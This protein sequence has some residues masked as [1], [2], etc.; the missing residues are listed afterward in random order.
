MGFLSPCSR[1]GVLKAST[2]DTPD[3]PRD[4]CLLPAV[5]GTRKEGLGLRELPRRA[6]PRP[7]HPARPLTL[8]LLVDHQ[9]EVVQLQDVRQPAQ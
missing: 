3:A 4:Q 5:K 7:A 9:G 1:L 2:A 6:P 8:D